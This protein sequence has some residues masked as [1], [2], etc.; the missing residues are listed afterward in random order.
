MVKTPILALCISGVLTL[1]L[2]IRQ[3]AKHGNQELNHRFDV[4]KYIPLAE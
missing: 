1:I 2:L 3:H 4:M